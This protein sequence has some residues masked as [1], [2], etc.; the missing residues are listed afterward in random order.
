MALKKTKLQTGLAIAR[1]A[2]K[3]TFS[4]KLPQKYSYQQFQSW[5]GFVNAKGFTWYGQMYEPTIGGATTTASM[6]INK[7]LYYPNTAEKANTVEFSLS[8]SQGD[9]ARDY[10]QNEGIVVKSFPLAVP[11]V[12]SLSANPSDSLGNTCTFSWNAVV[13][14]T[15]G[16]VFTD[17]EYQS[18]LVANSTETD[19]SKLK[20]NQNNSG[21]RTGRG[22]N[23]S[24]ITITE[25][26]T[27]IATGSHTRWFRVRS[28][29]PAGASNWRYA[30]RVYAV[31]SAPK[32]LEATP[33][34]LASGFQVLT[35]WSS[36]ASAAYPVEEN[37]LEYCVCVPDVGLTVP[38]GQTWTEAQRV[39]RTGAENAGLIVFNDTLDED[40]VMFVQVR[41]IHVLA[42][43]ASAPVIAK[44]GRLAA[45]TGVSAGAFT[46][47][48]KVT[49]TATNESDVPDSFLV[50]CLRR[51]SKPSVNAAVGIIPSG[52]TS[53]TMQ[54]PNMSGE[55]N[56]SF[57]V[58]AVV[59]TYT[60]SP[61]GDG[62]SSYKVTATMKSATTW[63]S[64]SVPKA[65]TNVTAVQADDSIR[66]GWDWSWEDATSAILS[67]SDHPDAWEST[68]EPS[69]YEVTS[70]GAS[71]WYIANLEAGVTWYVRV[72]LATE[73]ILG[74][75]SEVVAVDMSSAPAI[76][77]LTLSAAIIPEDGS[78][79]AYWAYSSTDGT[80][81]A[82]A[83][84]CECEITSSGIEYGEVIAETQTAQ[85]ITIYAEDVGWAVGEVHNLAVR[86]LSASGHLSDDWSAPVPVTIADPIYATITQSSLTAETVEGETVYF[87]ESLP[88]TATIT[89]AGAGGTTTLII[90]RAEDYQIDRPDGTNFNGFK[91]ETIA[92]MT[93]TGEA[94]ITVARANLLGLLDD[95]ARYRLIATIQDG[96]GQSDESVIEFT[97]RWSHQAVMPEATCYMK[98]GVSV[99]ELLT[100][101]GID[102]GDTFDIYRL[103]A[104]RPELVIRG[105]VAGEIYV[106]PFP[107]IG[108]HGG[109]R[110]V[111]NTIDG[112]YITATNELAWLDLGQEEGDFFDSKKSIIDFNGESVSLFYDSSQ[113]NSWTKDFRQTK[114]LGGSVQG[115]WN[116]GV[117]RETS[118]DASF[119]TLEDAESIGAMKR[120][121]EWTGICHIRTLDGS[122]FPC[123]VEVGESRDF[124]GDYLRA[125]FSLSVSRIDA[126]GFEGMTYDEYFGE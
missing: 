106:D 53:V 123:N 126:Q 5:I 4:W 70:Q 9:P 78:V 36:A 62:V 43:N 28:R 95:G 8:M 84:I 32:I 85:H 96:L 113:S 27:V 77:V 119:V 94:Q 86:V 49:V 38:S 79:T 72:R 105:A 103:T 99:I 108:E 17:V 120:L 40:E 89:G 61:R 19:G 87:L 116:K 83:E 63:S 98:D 42:D 80:R 20:W 31:P 58:Y 100:P 21:W 24:S 48:W 110:I 125:S 11:A 51:G 52:Q 118:F 46:S 124:G 45:P 29:G 82:Y 10:A 37:V 57:A 60:E 122:S 67:W 1:Q 26:N 6:N 66:V 3:F 35:K 73:D 117:L 64:G 109:H 39:K 15:N 23:Q 69:S 44:Y 2:N 18:I 16:Q 107:T 13:N 14:D 115:D 33:K 71:Q 25:S 30:K 102:E 50:V 41:A 65:P 34:N 88:L 91:G 112:D 12:P 111:T 22:T 75:W 68:D 97:V 121:A 114:Y 101:A 59:G 92:V 90:E 104:D 54:C 55:T 81:Q 7:A 76:P 93:Q 56:Y 47:D 74:P